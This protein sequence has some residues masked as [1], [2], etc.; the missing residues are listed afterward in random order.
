FAAFLPDALP[1]RIRPQLDEAGNDPVDRVRRRCFFALIAPRH[2][3]PCMLDL[4]ERSTAIVGAL[5]ARCAN[6]AGL[7]GL[8]RAFVR[9]DG[10]R[11]PPCSVGPAT[12]PDVRASRCEGEPGRP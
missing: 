8:V 3:A 6:C 5:A 12:D 9:T 7:C 11:N 10:S 4:L 1:P 2:L